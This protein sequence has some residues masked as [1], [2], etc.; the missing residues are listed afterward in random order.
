VGILTTGSG[1]H[2]GDNSNPDKPAPRNGLDPQ[3]LQHIHS[4]PAYATLALTIGLVVAAIVLKAR[5]VRT[6]VLWLLAIELVQVVVGISQARLGLP[7]LLVGIHMVLA[8][9]LVAAVTAVVLATR[10][11]AATS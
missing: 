6:F 8:G 7:E 10:E 4:W 3:L 11:A 5:R 1:P 2:A 9:C